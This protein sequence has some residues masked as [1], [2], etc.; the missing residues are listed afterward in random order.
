MYGNGWNSAVWTPTAKFI[1]KGI[2]KITDIQ[3]ILCSNFAA[4]HNQYPS[5]AF[6]PFL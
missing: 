6:S 2:E 4:L 5:L 3:S 1:V